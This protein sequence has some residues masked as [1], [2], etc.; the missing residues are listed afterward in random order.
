MIC[1]ARA[2]SLTQSVDV[3]VQLA[4]ESYHMFLYRKRYKEVMLN[5]E[6]MMVTVGFNRIYETI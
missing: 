4:G 6:K 3:A 2:D 5:V 1:I